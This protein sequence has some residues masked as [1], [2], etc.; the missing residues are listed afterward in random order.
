M[1]E[2]ACIKY[3]GG[4]VFT[5]S[6]KVT[7][8]ECVKRT[9]DAAVEL[10]AMLCDQFGLDPIGDGVIISHAEGAMRGIASNHADPGHL[11]R[12]LDLPYTMDTF[13]QAVKAAMVVWDGR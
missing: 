9:Y 8:Q 12:Q 3:T 4:S 13:R 6:D 10:F 7:A 5:C 2:P 1:C 11:W